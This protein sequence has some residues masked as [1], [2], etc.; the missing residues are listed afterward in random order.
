MRTSR[1]FSIFTYTI[2]L[3]TM[4]RFSFI[5]FDYW[6]E[7]KDRKIV[8]DEIYPEMQ[9]FIDAHEKI[10]NDNVK[11]IRDSVEAGLLSADSAFYMKRGKA[12]NEL[13]RAAKNS[14]H[15]GD[16]QA[17][18]QKNTDIFQIKYNYYSTSL[19]FT[20][21]KDI[22]ECHVP[23]STKFEDSWKYEMAKTYSRWEIELRHDWDFDR[24]HNGKAQRD[25]LREPMHVCYTLTKPKN[26]RC[27]G[28]F[29]DFETVIHS[30]LFS[31]C[32]Y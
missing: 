31:R 11:A 17:D 3:L 5:G 16:Y 24:E 8:R 13:H 10:Y 26:A 9:K 30:N 4:V 23:D 12:F 29:K 2:V 28:L 1:L 6:T 14:A 19:S 32:S 18:S 22:G 7:Y 20:L 21:Q 25:T 27:S 15:K